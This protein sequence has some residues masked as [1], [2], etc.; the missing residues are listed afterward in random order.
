MPLAFLNNNRTVKKELDELLIRMSGYVKPLALH[1]NL[2]KSYRASYRSRR[3]SA[4]P[5]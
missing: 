1:R 5:A 4:I 3:N 2:E